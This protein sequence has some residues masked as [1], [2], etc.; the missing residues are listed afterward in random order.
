MIEANLYLN[1]WV[2]CEN[3]GGIALIVNK[4]LLGS[5]YSNVISENK[6][7]LSLVGYSSNLFICFAARL[8]RYFE[9]F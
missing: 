5:N 2:M 1:S 9:L 6:G 3:Y 4:R 8:M 7:K